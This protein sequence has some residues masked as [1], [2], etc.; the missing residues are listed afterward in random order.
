MAYLPHAHEHDI[1]GETP[2]LLTRELDPDASCP[3][4]TLRTLSS[5]SLAPRTPLSILKVFILVALDIIV[6][7]AI[8]VPPAVP[9]CQG[10][11]ASFHVEQSTMVRPLTL[12][13]SKL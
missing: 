4:T 8:F 11:N 5:L 7:L 6:K 3:K 13:A 12:A 10:P 1:V 9:E 2:C